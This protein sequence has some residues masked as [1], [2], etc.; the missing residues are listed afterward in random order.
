MVRC[1][2]GIL[3]PEEIK[4][5]IIELQNF[6]SNFVKAKFVERE[7]LH[8]CF[9]FLGEK[10]EKEIE[11]V[12]EKLNEIG[13]NFESFEVK[14]KGIKLIPS[15]SFVRVIALNV[16][17]EKGISEGLRLEILNEIGG[18]SKPLHLTLCRVKNKE[19]KKFFENIEK[20]KEFYAGS[21]WVNSIQLI[22]SEL[23]KKG[24][25]YELIHEVKLK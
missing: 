18:D 10:N 25:S 7:N 17:D 9:S 23:S 2:I 1:F 14:V 20:V 13:K 19:R 22:K 6:L 12:K 15:Q 5:K 11:N 21:F 16:F 8:L 24:P 3:I 4:P